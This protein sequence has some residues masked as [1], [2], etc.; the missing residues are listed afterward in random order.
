[1]Q[2]KFVE[3]MHVVQMDVPRSTKDCYAQKTKRK[4]ETN[5]S[6]A[7]IRVS[8]LVSVGIYKHTYIHI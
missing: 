2:S 3:S 5:I 1:M 6:P 7:S 4:L 8:S